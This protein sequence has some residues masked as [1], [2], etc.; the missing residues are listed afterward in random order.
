[1]P[2]E[3]ANPLLLQWI[4]EWL[5]SAR[6]QNSK[7]VNT[8]KKAYDSMSACPLA[9]SHP[10]EA[11]Q[12][13]GLG[14]KLCDRLTEKL[15]A[16]CL[17]NGLP[18]PEMPHKGKKR[19]S[20]TN[21]DGSALPLRKTRK[22]RPYVPA[23]RSGPYALIL[24]L[25]SIAENSSAGLTKVQL[26]AASQEHCDSSFTAPSDPTKFHTAWD[27]M[28]TL[29]SKDLVYERGRPLKKYA[30]T[31]EGWEVAK[32]MKRVADSEIDAPG[33]LVENY[34]I[35]SDSR[36]TR[37]EKAA[38][39]SIGIADQDLGSQELVT[40]VSKEQSKS[41]KSSKITTTR[42]IAAAPLSPFSAIPDRSITSR[43]DVRVKATLDQLPGAPG[44]KNQQTGSIP[45]DRFGVRQARAARA[46]REVEGLAHPSS[47][48]VVDL[49][50]SEP[51]SPAP[52]L[53]TVQRPKPPV[54]KS[55]QQPPSTRPT[56]SSQPDR[57]SVPTTDPANPALPTD[58][59]PILI[60]PSSYTIRLVLD[61]REVRSKTDRDYIQ[62]A[63]STL[64]VPPLVR[65]LELG[66]ALW[67]AQLH[68]PT[69]LAPHGEEG[70]GSDEI[71]LDYII[72]RKRLDDL[73]SSLK[74]GRFHEQKF[75]LGKSGVGNVVYIVEDYNLPPETA[76][77]FAE[78]L[79]TALA[80]MQLVNGYFVKRTATLDESIKYLA[81]LTRM[82]EKLYAGRS[83]ALI[84]SA[85]L[86]PQNHLSLLTSLRET[87]PSSP[88]HLTYATFSALASK[89]DML[90][91]RDVFLKMLMC[92]RGV[93][94]E[95]ALAIQRIWPTPRSFV[96]AYETC[97][98]EGGEVGGLVSGR[99][100][101]RVGGAKVGKALSGRLADV[102]GGRLDR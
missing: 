86:T 65:S 58:F 34:D 41:S 85:F 91:L 81:R 101:A 52:S 9:F 48:A 69:Q 66:D 68:S 20:D 89:S 28:K 74:D 77:R 87:S 23:L 73:V 21:L 84:P 63:L 72:E 15:K 97:R 61:T 93:T 5:E 94:G 76:A 43:V 33:P 44:S 51:S 4:G 16:H 39:I 17:A 12:L 102:W 100:A 79:D 8:Y 19:P 18:V 38:N 3:C 10:S 36:A 26:I 60:P 88:H 98:Q 59:T 46:A 55:S 25:S 50:S 64:G 2:T 83:L 24:G 27:S 32:R 31:E 82:L 22:P 13:H 49:L 90:T 35:S 7:V 71:M 29:I 67:I 30:L 62:S 80:A 45:R 6:Q 11:Q 40:A 42:S 99:L 54:P 78:A 75:R 37:K 1:M 70:P 92:T 53:D 57:R 47:P 14:P 96:E 95:K 56:I